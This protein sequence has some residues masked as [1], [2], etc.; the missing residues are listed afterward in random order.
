MLQL[1]LDIAR[2]NIEFNYSSQDS[3]NRLKMFIKTNY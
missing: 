3:K 2:S 1:Q